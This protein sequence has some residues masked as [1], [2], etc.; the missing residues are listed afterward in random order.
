MDLNG[1]Y[2]QEYRINPGVPPGSVLSPT[3]FLVYTNELSDNDFCNVV[4]YTD[5]TLYSKWDQV[6]DLWQQ[7]ELA[8]ESENDL[9][10]TVC[11]FQCWKNSTCF[12]WTVK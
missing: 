7:L 1:K 11:W 3:L 5:T 4:M 6:S 10:D 2:S 9:R 12:I 8:S